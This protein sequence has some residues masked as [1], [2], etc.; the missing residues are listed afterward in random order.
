MSQSCKD[1]EITGHVSVEVLINALTWTEN[2]EED[3]GREVFAV[4]DWIP[5]K[6]NRKPKLHLGSL[7]LEYAFS[8]FYVRSLSLHPTFTT[9]SAM[10][11][12]DLP[13]FCN[14]AARLRRSFDNSDRVSNAA[15][16][17]P[18]CKARP[19]IEDTALRSV[20]VS[21]GE[22]DNHIGGVHIWLSEKVCRH[23]PWTPLKLTAKRQS[24]LCNGIVPQFYRRAR[25]ALDVPPILVA[26][27]G[28]RSLPIFFELETTRAPQQQYHITPTVHIVIE[29]FKWAN[30]LA[31]IALIVVLTNSRKSSCGSSACLIASTRCE[32]DLKWTG[33]MNTRANSS[34]SC[35]PKL[36]KVS[37]CGI[38][39]SNWPGLFV[40][41]GLLL[42]ATTSQAAS[43]PAFTVTSL[44]G[45]ATAG[46]TN[47]IGSAASFSGPISLTVDAS[48]NVYVADTT[49]NLIRKITP[50]NTV[51]TLAGSTAAG[52]ADGLGTSASF[53]S[54]T[55]IRIDTNGNLYV[56]DKLNKRIRLIASSGS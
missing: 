29:I 21:K 55:G 56:A 1:V 51:T 48:L 52:F 24:L 53:N 36:K 20:S 27:H 43:A 22:F 32:P 26:F 44:A 25:M 46:S 2:F 19:S 13:H 4:S 31:V 39:M 50:S 15:Y 5:I 6:A 7:F 33:K 37:C 34:P 30:M 9:G 40:A 3:I 18:P 38:S 49:N 10:E 12:G 28:I 17:H 14:V 23:I 35:D 41:L 16:F 54:P 11:S 45:S 8:I 42:Q 47:G